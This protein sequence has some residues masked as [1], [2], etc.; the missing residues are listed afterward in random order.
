MADTGERSSGSWWPTIVLWGTVMAVGALYL[1]SVEQ[2]RED[3][4]RDAAQAQHAVAEPDA[5]TKTAEAPVVEV[6]VVDAAV[7]EVVEVEVVPL[8]AHA[9]AGAVTEAMPRDQTQAP[10][11]QP[12]SASDQGQGAIDRERASILAEYEA[13]RRAAQADL[14][15][16]SSVERPRQPNAWYPNPT[17]GPLGPGQR[18]TPSQPRW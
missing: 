11:A 12:T 6:P 16:R 10:A 2:H 3:A 4:Q 18:Y 8:E 9:I 17:D 14:E 13:M 5:P 15:R 7:T 1:V